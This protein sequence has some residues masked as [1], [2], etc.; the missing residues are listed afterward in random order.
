M[1]LFAAHAIDVYKT[2]HVD[3]YDKNTTLV[4]SNLTARSGSHSNVKLSKGVVFIG[5]QLFIK[6]Y[7]INSWN[8]TFFNIDEDEAVRKYERRISKT[9]NSDI[10]ADHL[11]KL[12]QL[13]YLP[14]VIKALP[15]GSFVPYKVPLLTIY[16]TLPEFY[17]LPNFIECAVSQEIWPLINTA[18]TMREY[19]RLFC[20]YAMIT[21][22]DLSFVPYQGHDFSCRGMFGR[23]AAAKSGFAAVACGTHGTD[24]VFAMDVAED[25]YYAN[26]DEEI[27]GCSV[28]ATEHSV[29][30]SNINTIENSSEFYLIKDEFAKKLLFNN[31][32]VRHFN[33]EEITDKL[34]AE[35]AYVKKLIT[36]IYPTGIV[37]IVADSYDFWGFVKYI[38]PAL[39][40][41]I[42]NRDG[43]VVIRGDSGNPVDIICGTLMHKIINR[44]SITSMFSDFQ[45]IEEI[46]KGIVDSMEG[47]R[48][49]HDN[50]DIIHEL[51]LFNKEFFKLNIKID[52]TY[53]SGEYYDDPRIGSAT[54]DSIEKYQ[55]DIIEM[56]LVESLYKIFGG[57]KNSKGYIELNPKVGAIYGDS[58]TL[59]RAAQILA[60]LKQKGFASNNV[61]LGIGSYTFQGNSTRDTH[62]IAMK[63]TY[64]EVNDNGE[65]KRI[66]IYKQPKTDDGTK[67]S[68]KGL[69]MVERIGDKYS[70][71]D[72]CCWKEER[73]GCLETVFKDGKLLI[74]TSLKE[75]R[76][77]VKKDLDGELENIRRV[78]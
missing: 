50:G 33:R 47:S 9:I 31:I 61:V 37:S 74:E 13:G 2:G 73:R 78:E 28:N 43:K 11:R 67:K 8:K 53:D 52:S 45:S 75:I 25:Y 44:F 59:E 14:L 56:G 36:E 26:P 5:L 17:W 72:E 23:E 51:V 63:A 16:N 39:K 4:Y 65:I 6:D 20:E 55:P 1:D 21:C 29:M 15:E 49:D 18:T 30:C 77:R 42:L 19:L 32:D 69:L 27:I 60:N 46:A 57:T 68:A 34:I 40:H 71:R 66:P 41:E 76:N 3:Q 64:C 10:T 58:I 38:L 12:H 48:T 24:S 54:L 62:G 7:I 22:D 70:L 35:Y